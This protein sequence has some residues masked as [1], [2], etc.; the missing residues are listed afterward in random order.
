MVDARPVNVLNTHY[1]QDGRRAREKVGKGGREG[2]K[3]KKPQRRLQMRR[4]KRRRLGGRKEVNVD[5][6]KVLLVQ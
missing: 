6:K 1:I 5:K 4:G 2:K 3:R